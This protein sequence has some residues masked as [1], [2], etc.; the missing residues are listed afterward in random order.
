MRRPARV[1][2]C[3]QISTYEGDAWKVDISPIHRY[4]LRFEGFNPL[5][6]ADQDAQALAQLVEWVQTSKLIP[7]ETEHTGLEELPAALEGIFRGS[8][9]GKMIVSL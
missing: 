5:L 6:F 2:E 4:G 3:G 7:L 1:V 8:N 9:I